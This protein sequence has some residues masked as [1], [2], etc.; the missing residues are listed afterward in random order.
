MAETTEDS[1]A[2][3][4]MEHVWKHTGEGMGNS[5]RRLNGAMQDALKLAIEHGMRFN[6]DDFA[7]VNE[8]FRPGYWLNWEGAYSRAVAGPH[9]ANPSAIKALEKQLSRKAFIVHETASLKAPK[10]R[11]HEGQRFEWHIDL[12][13]KVHVTVTSFTKLK[14]GTQAV[15]A[16][17]YKTREY[18]K[19]TGYVIGTEKIEKRFTI[20]HADIAEY[21]TA[22]RAAA[23]AAEAKETD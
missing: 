19:K 3:V 18:D 5:W 2:L 7:Y 16:C 8:H 1:P 6:E 15:I 11:L 17:S 12:K 21:H 9:G 23:K 13:S 20:T 14:D 10:I 4:L 22:I